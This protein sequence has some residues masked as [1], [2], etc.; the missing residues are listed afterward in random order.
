[1][2]FNLS[3][4]Y[5]MENLSRFIKWATTNIHCMPSDRVTEYMCINVFCNIILYYH[6][7]HIYNLCYMPIA[8]SHLISA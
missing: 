4:H 3:K 5:N 6:H 8:Y 2:E 1:M 7:A